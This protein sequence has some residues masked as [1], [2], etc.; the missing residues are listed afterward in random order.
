MT[1]LRACEKS[2]RSIGAGRREP[3]GQPPSACT[4]ASTADATPD[5]R[6]EGVNASAV[7]FGGVPAAAPVTTNRTELNLAASASAADRSAAPDATTTLQPPT[8]S[9]PANG[10]ACA[11]V[12]GPVT[13]RYDTRAEVA[14][15]ASSIPAHACAADGSAR[16]F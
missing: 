9:D 14:R 8:S 15:E 12:A 11:A 16:P 10:S 4:P 1:H 6:P 2:G 3:E 13:A 7:T 5:R